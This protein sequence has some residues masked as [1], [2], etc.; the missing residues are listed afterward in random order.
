MSVLGAVAATGCS[1][2]TLRVT[3]IR[4][5]IASA[6]SAALFA[7]LD[8]SALETVDFR[9]SNLR[10]AETLVP[11]TRLLASPAC[12]LRELNLRWCR[13]LFRPSGDDADAR[14]RLL[15]EGAFFRALS[16]NSSLRLLDLSR[17]GLGE[18]AAAHLSAALAVRGASLDLL[19][20]KDNSAAGAGKAQGTRVQHKILGIVAA[21]LNR[22][23]SSLQAQ[24]LL[25]AQAATLRWWFAGVFRASTFRSAVSPTPAWRRWVQPSPLT[26]ARSGTCASATFLAEN[27]KSRMT[28]PWV[29]GAVW[30][31]HDSPQRWEQTAACGPSHGAQHALSCL[32]TQHGA[33]H[34]GR[35]SLAPLCRPRRLTRVV[36]PISSPLPRARYTPLSYH[37]VREP[38]VHP[39]A[40]AAADLRACEAALCAS[41]RANSTLQVLDLC[42]VTLGHLGDVAAVAGALRENRSL[43]LFAI[44]GVRC[45][46]APSFC[47]PCV[48]AVFMSFAFT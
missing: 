32:P 41:L 7:A 27:G 22:K 26:L 44:G 19:D 47:T 29:C 3:S 15:A 17:T 40:R 9:S 8:T 11:L 31:R 23:P 46:H 45:A 36:L 43:R 39:P 37:R 13:D 38:E 12:R 6:A 5:P 1:L 35:M 21:G 28:A 4:S 20:L 10:G 30:G 48:F 34:R 2:R 16:G 33:A 24:F 14:A 42:G 18:E 25:P